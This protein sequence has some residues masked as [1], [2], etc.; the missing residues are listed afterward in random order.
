MNV[1]KKLGADCEVMQDI[2]TSG[3][4]SGSSEDGKIRADN[5]LECRLEK[6]R[7][8]STL[9]ITSLILGDPDG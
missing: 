8:L 1:I 6:I 7:S 4:L 5:T 3:G 2:T 9:E